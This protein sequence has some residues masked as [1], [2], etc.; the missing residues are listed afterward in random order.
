[1]EVR[2]SIARNQPGSGGS[3]HKPFVVMEPYHPNQAAKINGRYCLLVVSA[4]NGHKHIQRAHGRKDWRD[5][6]RLN[7]TQSFRGV[8]VKIAT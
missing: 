5:G 4:K 3:F 1:M 7:L 6:G 2:R 8:P